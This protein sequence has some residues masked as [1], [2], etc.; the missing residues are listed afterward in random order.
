MDPPQ[1]ADDFNPED[2]RPEDNIASVNSHLMLADL[3]GKLHKYIDIL[4]HSDPP[5]SIIQSIR[6]G[7]SLLPSWNMRS[8]L[9][10]EDFAENLDE[11]TSKLKQ[12]QTIC[13]SK[14]REACMGSLPFPPEVNGMIFDHI[15]IGKYKEIDDSYKF[16]ELEGKEKQ[17]ITE[18]YKKVAEFYVGLR[19]IDWDDPT[20]FPPDEED[21][22]AYEDF[23]SIGAD[24]Q[25]DWWY[26][27]IATLDDIY[28]EM[29]SFSVP[30][31]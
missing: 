9:M 29:V 21:E 27:N 19:D 28:D 12:L 2:F 20:D 11:F 6:D 23:L 8:F 1:G 16:E 15:P 7:T 5:N 25:A 31:M 14:S 3:C 24:M 17:N 30:N 26:D 4:L 10:E 22:K 13:L 18:V